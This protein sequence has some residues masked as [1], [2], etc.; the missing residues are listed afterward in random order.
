VKTVGGELHRS[1][2]VEV[3]R[4]GHNAVRFVGTIREP[5]VGA[6]LHP[7]IEQVHR[8]AVA[9]QLPEVVLD[10]RELQYANASFWRCIVLWL[11]RIGEGTD[12]SY[13]LRIRSDATYQWQKVGVPALHAFALD[14]QGRER[15]I[16][17][18]IGP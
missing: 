2:R 10:I 17:E 6:W 4:F 18:G 8:A 15:L 12:G 11:K 3:S 14:V 7:L 9:D 5:D 1:E 16:V 13:V